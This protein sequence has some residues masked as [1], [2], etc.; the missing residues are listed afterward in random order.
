MFRNLIWILG[1]NSW[2][3]ELPKYLN[4]YQTKR[5]LSVETTIIYKSDIHKN[6]Y[7]PSPINNIYIDKTHTYKKATTL[8]NVYVILYFIYFLGILTLLC[9]QP[10]NLILEILYKEVNIYEYITLFFLYILMPINYL[11]TKN[12]FSTNHFDTFFMKSNWKC[13]HLCNK[14]SF[15]SF[16]TSIGSVIPYIFLVEQVKHFW[17]K[18][19]NYFW[20]FFILTE[21]IGRNIILLNGG[22]FLLTFLNHLNELKKF[23]DN[24]SVGIG[25]LNFDKFT[26]LSDMI[27]ILSKYRAELK[28][29]IERYEFLVSANTA[30][31]AI[32]LILFIHH[33]YIN[34][35]IN[36]SSIDIFILVNLI[37][38][39][40]SQSIFFSV[41][42]KYSYMRSNI[43]TYINSP[44]FINKFIQR[45]K[46][47][48]ITNKSQYETHVL[49]LEEE[50]ASTL[51][52]TILDK[53]TKEN[54]I[55]FHIMGIST[56][57]GSLIKKVLTFSTLFYTLIRFF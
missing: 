37:Y 17:A 23:T 7:S 53:M 4:F 10:V 11:W 12:Y 32:S 1:L 49:I 52:W 20:I 16:I 18:N 50:S 6:R 28:C 36:M 40:L 46:H 48:K 45:S 47:S 34:L 8:Q 43:N 35:T 3:L 42:L 39:I 26:V 27:L 14:L 44:N 54:W 13:N 55:D 22:I 5:K 51:D 33:K 57:D 38:Y 56:R 41:L 24:I 9:I 25:C 31:G 19:T 2:E 21:T 29:S 30:L 15:L